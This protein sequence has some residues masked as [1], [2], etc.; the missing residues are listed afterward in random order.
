MVCAE[1]HD[2]C[3]IWRRRSTEMLRVKLSLNA[4]TSSSTNGGDRWIES[5]ISHS[6]PVDN[7]P[8]NLRPLFPS[9]TLCSLEIRKFE[10]RIFS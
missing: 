2:A 8:T 4:S 3:S 1:Y 5:N 6:H 10:R 7:D 9:Q